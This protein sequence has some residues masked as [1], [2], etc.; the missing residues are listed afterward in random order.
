MQGKNTVAFGVLSL[1]MS[2]K[3]YILL[4][5]RQPPSQN[6]FI[7]ICLVSICYLYHLIFKTVLLKVLHYRHLKE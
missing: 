5:V 3:Y 7:Y 4:P 1:H 6:T 2:F